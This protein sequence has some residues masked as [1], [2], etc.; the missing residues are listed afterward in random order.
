LKSVIDVK[1]PYPGLKSSLSAVSSTS[2][3][4]VPRLLFWIGEVV[5]L[6]SPG[7]VK[8][9]NGFASLLRGMTK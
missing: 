7:V 5:S 4:S 6:A 9:L 3:L 1:V 2:R 8:S